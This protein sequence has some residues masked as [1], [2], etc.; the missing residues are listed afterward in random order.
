LL[1]LEVFESIIRIDWKGSG[2][3]SR[4]I[5]VRWI[6][7]GVWEVKVGI[8]NNFYSRKVDLKGFIYRYNKTFLY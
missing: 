1:G 5:G 4:R 2:G 3:L 8:L 6:G 7:V